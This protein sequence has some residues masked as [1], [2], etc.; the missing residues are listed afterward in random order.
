MAPKAVAA[1]KTPDRNGAM[2][3]LSGWRSAFMI[4]GT[5]AKPSLAIAKAIAI[6]GFEVNAQNIKASAE[7]VPHP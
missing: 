2:F 6:L 3:S 1:L 5:A 4:V 7:S